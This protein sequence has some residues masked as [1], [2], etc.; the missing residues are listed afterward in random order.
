MY[1]TSFF[2]TK[3]TKT[4]T[5]QFYQQIDAYVSL[6]FFAKKYL[7]IYSKKQTK[8]PP[9]NE[10]FLYVY[11]SCS[12]DSEFVCSDSSLSISSL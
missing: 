5:K 11:Y 9:A 1:Y 10:W 6:S 12:E 4:I 7:N 3:S 8:K 2:S